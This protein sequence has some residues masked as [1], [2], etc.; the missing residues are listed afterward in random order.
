MV[1]AQLVMTR[2]QC[3]RAHVEVTL[4]NQNSIAQTYPIFLY[5]MHVVCLIHGAGEPATG[6][7]P[8]LE[9]SLSLCCLCSHCA[10]VKQ[11]KSKADV[12]R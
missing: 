7:V 9:M 5:V 3:D 2:Q 6:D 11:V 4:S 1:L 12:H 10:A 8:A